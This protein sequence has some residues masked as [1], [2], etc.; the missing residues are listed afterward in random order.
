MYKIYLLS[1]LIIA[2]INLPAQITTNPA[3]PVALKKVTITFNSA[4]D[5]RLGY[6]TG[7]LYAHTGVGIEGRGNWQ[8]IVGGPGSWGKNDLQPKLANK[9][10]GIYEIEIIPDINSFYSVGSNEK[11]INMSFVFRSSNSSQQ[12][13]DLIINVFE[14]GLVISINQPSGQSVYLQGQPVAIS[15]NSS[16]EAQIKLFAGG[17]EISQNTGTSIS[18][19]HTFTESGTFLL[20]PKQRQIVKPNGTQFRFL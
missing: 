15:A 18:A 17:S 13:N 2:G 10:N 1:L 9:G 4:E 20:L 14:E 11:V 19:N 5:S 8:N 3:L 6:F 12:T 16:Q 7:D